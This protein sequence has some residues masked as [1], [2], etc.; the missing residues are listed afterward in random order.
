MMSHNRLVRLP[1]AGKA[2]L[3]LLMASMSAKASTQKAT[4]PR[5]RK[6]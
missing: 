4:M 5:A 6:K 3:G 2:W 1:V